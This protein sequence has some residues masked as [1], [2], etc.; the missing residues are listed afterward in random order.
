MQAL[1]QAFDLVE[2]QGGVIAPEHGQ[3]PESPVSAIVVAQHLAIGPMHF[4]SLQSYINQDKKETRKLGC[5]YIYNTLSD[6]ET[7]L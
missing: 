6:Q 5:S 3:L 1:G 2:D 4:P 7:L